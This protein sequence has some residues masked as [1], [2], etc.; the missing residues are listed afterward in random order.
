VKPPFFVFE[1]PPGGESIGGARAGDRRRLLKGSFYHIACLLPGRK[2]ASLL[3]I[4]RT[5]FKMGW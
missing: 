2:C 5:R 3:G 1:A 4:Q